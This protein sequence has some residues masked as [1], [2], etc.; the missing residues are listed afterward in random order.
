[1]GNRDEG[2]SG[3]S[4]ANDD[5]RLDNLRVALGLFMDDD[6]IFSVSFKWWE[7]RASEWLLV[8]EELEH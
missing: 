1:M 6:P 5:H 3:H 2:S 8:A 7:D 4:G